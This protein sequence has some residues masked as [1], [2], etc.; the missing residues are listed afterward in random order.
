M[1]LIARHRT[2]FVAA[3]YGD[4]GPSLASS[5]GSFSV[6]G[7][8]SVNLFDGGRIRSDQTAA[9]AEIERR[10]N[11]LADLRGRIDFEVRSALLDLSTEQL[12]AA[13]LSN[14]SAAVLSLST[15]VNSS[16]SSNVN[17]TPCGQC[18]A[19]GLRNG[20]RLLSFSFV[21]APNGIC[22]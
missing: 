22:F 1:P 6:T 13:S 17:M 10:R 2:A 11:E 8:V 3:N 19:I 21:K 12:T 16:N 7:T 9:D 20:R 15:I 18:W 14:A 5:H 4:I